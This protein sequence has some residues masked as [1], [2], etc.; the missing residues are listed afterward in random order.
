MAID[1]PDSLD[2]Q[3]NTIHTRPSSSSQA[4]HVPCPVTYSDENHSSETWVPFFYF[5]PQWAGL[6]GFR[7]NQPMETGMRILGA[8]GIFSPSPSKL[9]QCT[10]QG[11]IPAG[12]TSVV[13]FIPSPSPSP[14]A[15]QA[16]SELQDSRAIARVSVSVSCQC[17]CVDCGREKLCLSRLAGF[18]ALRR[19]GTAQNKPP[20]KGI[21]PQLAS[22]TP[23]QIPTSIAKPTRLKPPVR[24]GTAGCFPVISQ[25]WS[26]ARPSS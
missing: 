13:H 19:L 3:P 15:P 12:W 7:P 20:R 14:F 1:R 22:A 11:P 21:P 16:P 8:M 25:G 23:K 4:Q 6:G 10:S 9:G 24:C 18:A 5:L 2:W 26:T 17:H